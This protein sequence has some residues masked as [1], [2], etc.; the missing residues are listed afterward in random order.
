MSIGR[1]YIL[2]QAA[3][4]FAYVPRRLTTAPARVYSASDISVA[5]GT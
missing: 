5:F 2:M 1:G 4:A 3:D